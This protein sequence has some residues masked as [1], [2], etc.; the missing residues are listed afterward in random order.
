MLQIADSMTFSACQQPFR[1]P[2][3]AC[4]P[5]LVLLRLWNACEIADRQAYHN[6]DTGD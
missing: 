2:D 4:N 6:D 1:I 3:I 5:A